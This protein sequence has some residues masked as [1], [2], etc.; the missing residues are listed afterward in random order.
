[1]Q[2]QQSSNVKIRRFLSLWIRIVNNLVPE[3]PPVNTCFYSVIGLQNYREMKRF[4][5]HVLQ[6]NFTQ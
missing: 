6:N 2:Q 1:M 3:G 4:V 5:E